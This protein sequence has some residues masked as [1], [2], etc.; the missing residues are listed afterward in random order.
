MKKK[1]NIGIFSTLDNPLLGL[2]LVLI[3]KKI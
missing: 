3:K 2:L 1:I